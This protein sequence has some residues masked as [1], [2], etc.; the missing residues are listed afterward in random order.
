[1]NP[2]VRRGVMCAA[3]TVTTAHRGRLRPA[4]IGAPPGLLVHLVRAAFWLAVYLG[5]VLAPLFV[6]LVGTTQ[7]H[8]GFWWDLSIAFGFA[9]TAMM[10]VQFLLTAREARRNERRADAP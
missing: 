4:L 3:D 2:R 7:T 10:G 9:G 5:L 6:L 8:A 1:M